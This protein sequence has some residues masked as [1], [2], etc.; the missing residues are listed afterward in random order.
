VRRRSGTGHIEGDVALLGCTENR[1]Q[2]GYFNLG[3]RF[4][5]GE[6]FDDSSPSKRNNQLIIRIQRSSQRAESTDVV[7]LS[8]TSTYEVARC[9]AGFTMAD[10]TQD[11]DPRLCDRSMGTARVAIGDGG[12]VIHGSFDPYKTCPNAALLDAYSALLSGVAQ[13]D[14]D[15]TDP[16]V[17]ALNPVGCPATCPDR[18]SWVEFSVFGRAHESSGQV[19]PRFI[20]NYDEQ[21]KATN[22]HLGLCDVATIQANKDRRFVPAPRLTGTLDGDFDFDLRR[23]QGAQSF[24]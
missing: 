24:P 6:P 13:G 16:G 10:G 14:C 3:A 4:F 23:G 2:T 15:S 9:V 7:A 5:A 19:D 1:D 18:N 20:V 22:L 11:W 17:M 12:Q 8:I 21:I